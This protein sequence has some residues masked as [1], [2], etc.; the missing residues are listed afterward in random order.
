VRKFLLGA[1]A[2]L[3]ALVVLVVLAALFGLVPVAADGG[4]WW[5]EA[6]LARVARDQAVRRA[7]AGL[8]P[9]PSTTDSLAEGWALYEDHCGGCHGFPDQSNLFGEALWPPAPDFAREG[10]DLSPAE[11]FWVA[12][13]GIRNTGMPAYGK[14]LGDEDLWKVA[15]F[16]SRIRQLPVE[17]RRKWERS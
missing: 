13:H 9:L 12:R 11:I 1:A 3:A 16:V 15:G 10:T 17:L 6:W 8:T 5:L 4:S 7:A 14:L 2:S